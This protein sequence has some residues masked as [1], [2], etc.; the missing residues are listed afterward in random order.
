MA[1]KSKAYDMATTYAEE[2]HSVANIVEDEDIIDNTQN[3]CRI[4]SVYRSIKN[5]TLPNQR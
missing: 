5:S 2:L 3:M 4:C 1:E